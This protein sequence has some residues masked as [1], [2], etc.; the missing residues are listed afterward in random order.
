MTFQSSF[1]IRCRLVPNPDSSPAATYSIQHVQTDAEFRATSL[2]EVTNWMTAQNL[3]YVTSMMEQMP[4]P[5]GDLTGER[6]Q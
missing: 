3:K 2:E 4:A 1:L 6:G 5:S